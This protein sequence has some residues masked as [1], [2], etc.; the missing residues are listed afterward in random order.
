MVALAALAASV[1]LQSGEVHWFLPGTL[2]PAEV[3]HCSTAAGVVYG[4]VPNHG[5]ATWA[6]TGHRHM[7]IS[8][9][10][11]GA[12]EAACNA[13]LAG[14]R[15]PRL[16]YVIGQNGVALIRGIDRLGQLE[17][18]YGRPSSTR[19]RSSCT[20][21]WARAG[22][23]ARFTSC[24]ASARLVRATA[25]S[26]R[27]SSLNGVHIG[28]PLARMLFEAPYAK[29]LG[30]NHW[31]LALSHRHSIVAVT[32]HARVVRLVAKLG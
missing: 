9:A 20:V 7:S 18:R 32:S 22:L 26:T 25:T 23:W 2:R 31:R 12:V 13:Q 19:R 14:R 30:P 11:N 15:I 6:W 28:D 5:S 4:R 17:R 24:S 16:P 1:V 10:T 27:W 29:R 3:V 8:R 21:V